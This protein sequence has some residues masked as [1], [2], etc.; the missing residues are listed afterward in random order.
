MT[1]SPTGATR[2]RGVTY[3]EL[4]I[5]LMIM[6]M[7]TVAVVPQ[8]R[9]SFTALTFRQAQSSLIGAL[10]Y[11]HSRAIAQRQL[12]RVAVVTDDQP[13]YQV[14]VQRPDQA[15]DW[16]PIP[17]RFGRRRLLPDGTLMEMLAPDGGART[18]PAVTFYPNGRAD[19]A[20]IVLRT[21]R[22][23]SATIIVDA[24]TGQIQVKASD[25]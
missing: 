2:S 23:P 7:V 19:P 6:A 8:W 24:A 20:Q 9:G 25:Q 5:V 14:F 18:P 11:A 17:G 10:R 4:I 22:G 16:Q 1:T 3:L 13:G 21:P 12:V 15:D